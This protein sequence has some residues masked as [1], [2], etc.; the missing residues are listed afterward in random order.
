VAD[1]DDHQLG[2]APIQKEYRDQMEILARFLDHQFNGEAK[3]K[4]R[5]VG[6]VLLVFPFGDRGGRANFISNG[7]DRKEIVILMK[8]M[9]ARFEGMPEQEGKA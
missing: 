9:I 5:E 4:H 7:A 3:G 1:Q 2:D 8:E 6:Y